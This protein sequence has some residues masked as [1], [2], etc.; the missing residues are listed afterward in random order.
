MTTISG[1]LILV[2][3]RQVSEH[4]Y[5]F[6]TEFIF[7]MLLCMTCSTCYDSDSIVGNKNWWKSWGCTW[8]R[9]LN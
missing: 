8:D 1:S 3:S 4:K 7:Y 6:S 2:D 5:L 9:S